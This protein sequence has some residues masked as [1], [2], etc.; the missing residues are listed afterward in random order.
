[1]PGE[2]FGVIGERLSVRGRIDLAIHA[3]GNDTANRGSNR[4]AEGAPDMLSV[5]AARGI[6]AKMNPAKPI[7]PSRVCQTHFV[8]DGD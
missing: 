8:L 7:S 5:Y 4:N 3:P 6:L 2:A 1:M